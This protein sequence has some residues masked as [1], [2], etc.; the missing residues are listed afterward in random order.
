MA[1]TIVWENYSIRIVSLKDSTM[2]YLNQRKPP[3]FVEEIQVRKLG[4]FY[5]VRLISSLGS[6]ETVGKYKT[7]S[8][9]ERRAMLRIKTGN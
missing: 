9:A 2:Y 4:K 3:R 1:K 6:Y 5:V 8:G 7:R